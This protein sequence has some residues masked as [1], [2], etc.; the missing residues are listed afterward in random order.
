MAS[1]APQGGRAQRV[2]LT[3]QDGPINTNLTGVDSSVSILAN[4]FYTEVAMGNVPGKSI[5]FMFGRNTNLGAAVEDLWETG[6][7]LVYPTAGEQWE[8]LSSS[9][10]DTAAGTGAN[11]VAVVYLDTNYVIQQELIFLNG[12]TPVL[13]VAADI[14]RPKLLV[15]PIVGSGGENAGTITARVAGGGAIRGTIIPGFNN[16]LD[17]FYTVPVDHSVYILWENLPV[18]RNDGV[19]FRFRART[20]VGGP[21]FTPMLS[22]LFNSAITSNF[23]APIAFGERTDLRLTALTTTGGTSSVFWV[24]QLLLVDNTVS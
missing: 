20:A 16:N 21:F 11:A 15:T 13:T 12:V 1:R 9:A 7:S 10:A 4:D 3:G 6:G 8:V 24:L 22:E 5:D 17:G 14:F 23:G 18:G 19:E 2:W